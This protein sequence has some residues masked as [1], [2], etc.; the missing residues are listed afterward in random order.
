MSGADVSVENRAKVRIRE[1]IPNAEATGKQT[2]NDK[3]K[4][5]KYER[6]RTGHPRDD[7]G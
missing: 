2:G 1:D 7:N 4:R 5:W 6:D 3:E